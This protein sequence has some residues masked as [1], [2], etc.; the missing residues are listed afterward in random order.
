MG[1]ASA[2]IV[3]ASGWSI[4][5]TIP[6]TRTTQRQRRPASSVVDGWQRCWDHPDLYAV[7]CGSI[8]TVA[9]SNPSLTMAA[10]ALRSSEEM[11][12]DLLGRRRIASA[13]PPA[14]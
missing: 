5:T 14:A 3:P 4:S 2:L 10:L 11:H 12:R 7:G 1:A 6:L 8:S 9:T 13:A